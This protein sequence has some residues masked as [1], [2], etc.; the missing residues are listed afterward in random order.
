M[1]LVPQKVPHYF[2]V[3]QGKSS[4]LLVS[5]NKPAQPFCYQ[6]APQETPVQSDRPI[7]D[8]AAWS[9]Q[10]FRIDHSECM[11]SCEHDLTMDCLPC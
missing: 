7:Q 6:S 1:W 8:Q 9:P 3:T 10:G 2:R 4:L 11:T 5:I